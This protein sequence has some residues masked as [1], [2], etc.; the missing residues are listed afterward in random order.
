LS[1]K[2]VKDRVLY[3]EVLG[4]YTLSFIVLFAVQFYVDVYDREGRYGHIKKASIF[5]AS[6]FF[7]PIF[8]LYY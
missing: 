3:L 5:M 2:D 4:Q 6:L 1:L 8:L 7:P